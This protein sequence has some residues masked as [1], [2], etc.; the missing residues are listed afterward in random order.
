[1]ASRQSPTI[2]TSARRFLPIS[3]G[4]MSTWTTLA[5]GAKE[6]RLP[7]TRSSKRAP[8]LMIRSLRCRPATAATVPCMPGMPRCCGWLS[9]KAP[10]AIRV[11]TTGMPVNSASSR[12]SRDARARIVP[13]PTYSTGRRA[14]RTSFAASRICLACGLVTGR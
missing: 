6:S 4:S 13:P 8:R 11:V 5:P 9:G 14:S 10:R 12:S 7:V 1:M 2:G 3:A